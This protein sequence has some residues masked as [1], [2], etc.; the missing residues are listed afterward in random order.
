MFWAGFGAGLI[1]GGFLGVF[2]I[3]LC[4]CGKEE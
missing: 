1:V 4:L 3:G 2:L